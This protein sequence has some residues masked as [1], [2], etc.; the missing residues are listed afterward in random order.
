MPAVTTRPREWRTAARRAASSQSRRIT[1]PW[2]LPAVLAS[3]TPIQRVRIEAD[4]DGMRGSTGANS[5][6]RT[7]DR[8]L[9]LVHADHGA[10][11]R[12]VAG[13]IRRDERPKQGC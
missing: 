3:V 2:T 10:L 11:R 4:S 12:L 1:P 6:G 8:K 5:T 7:P 13:L 9:H